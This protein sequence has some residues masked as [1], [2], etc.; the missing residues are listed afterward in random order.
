MPHVFK[1]LKLYDQREEKFLYEVPDVY[2]VHCAVY[3][4]E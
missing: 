2:K 3:A 4:E 1:Y